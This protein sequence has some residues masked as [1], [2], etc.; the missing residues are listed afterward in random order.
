MPQHYRSHREA[1]IESLRNDPIY[2]EAYLDA[3][4]ADG[5][6]E[7]IL[8]TL[9]DMTAAF[10]G[11]A[12]I[13]VKTNLNPTTLYRTLSP[14]GNPSIANFSAILNAMGMRLSVQSL[15]RD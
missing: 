9:R 2:A 14:K 12:E 10:G 5:D 6:Q 8:S 15:H 1:K 7:E 4:L 11:M 3:V 13:A